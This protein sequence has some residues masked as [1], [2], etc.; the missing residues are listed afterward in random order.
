MEVEVSS[1][2]GGAWLMGE[3]TGFDEDVVVSDGVVS[4]RSGEQ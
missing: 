4:L 3:R 2:T 1:V